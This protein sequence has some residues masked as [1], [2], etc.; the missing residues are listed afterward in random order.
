MS[1]KTGKH[2]D[3]IIIKYAEDLLYKMSAKTDK[4]VSDVSMAIGRASHV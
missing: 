3:D 1:A 2:V 4:H